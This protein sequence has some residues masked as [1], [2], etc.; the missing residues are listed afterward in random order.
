MVCS[1]NIVAPI[2]SKLIFFMKGSV[3]PHSNNIIPG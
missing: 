2:T 1:E 3:A